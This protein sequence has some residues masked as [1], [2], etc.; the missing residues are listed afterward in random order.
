MKNRKR[1]AGVIIKESKVLMIH[2]FKNGDEY[3]VLPG[4]G[5]E[6]GESP[7]DALIREIKEETSLEIKIEKSSGNFIDEFGDEHFNFL[8]E[9]ISGEPKFEADSP[10]VKRNGPNI[11]YE[12]VWKNLEE[13]KD[14]KIYPIKTKEILLDL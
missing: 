12:L 8:C 6:K 10:E 3:F 4:G 9:Y 2:R 7:E 5:I 11:I 13:I 14:L 1:S